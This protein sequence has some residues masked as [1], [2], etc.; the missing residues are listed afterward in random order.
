MYDWHRA[1]PDKA[2]RFQLAMEG[3]SQSESQSSNPTY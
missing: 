1:H 2:K 3:V